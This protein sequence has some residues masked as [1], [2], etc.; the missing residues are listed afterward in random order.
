MPILSAVVV[1]LGR[2]KL[3][4][5]NKT[6]HAKRGEVSDDWAGDLCRRA[7]QLHTDVHGVFCKSESL[8][9]DQVLPSH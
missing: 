1:V 4:I 5:K 7:T 2:N 9:E 3:E 8:R 6:L